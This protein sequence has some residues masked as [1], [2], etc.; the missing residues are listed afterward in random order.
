MPVTSLT[1]QTAAEI[2]RQRLNVSIEDLPRIEVLIPDALRRLGRAVTAKESSDRHFL[3]KSINATPGSGA[4]DLSSSTFAN[5]FID[6]YREEGA[7]RAQ[8]GDPTIFFHTPTLTSLLASFP[9]D[10][11]VVFYHLHGLKRLVFRNPTDGLITTFATP[12]SLMGAFMPTFSDL[13]EELDDQL[14]D[15]IQEVFQ[16]VGGINYLKLD[17]EVGARAVQ[18][19]G[20]QQ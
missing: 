13:P 19:L 5:V 17:P 8:N 2:A 14:I 1:I 12:V 3:M 15:R 6:T 11:S 4:I 20:T 18:A 9:K 16:L 10:D 7:I